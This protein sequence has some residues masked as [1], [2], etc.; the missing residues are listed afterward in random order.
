MNEYDTSSEQSEDHEGF[1]EYLAAVMTQLAD[2]SDVDLAKF[3]LDKRDPGEVADLLHDSLV[4]VWDAPRREDG[5]H[6]QMLK[7]RANIWQ[8]HEN[9]LP[10][11]GQRER[12]TTPRDSS[13]ILQTSPGTA[14]KSTGGSVPTAKVPWD[15][16]VK[17]AANEQWAETHTYD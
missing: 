16:S 15:L 2:R 1:G 17:C 11:P 7:E 8:H 13:A 3:A 5:E 9:A 6:V 14:L 4:K 10:K 12:A